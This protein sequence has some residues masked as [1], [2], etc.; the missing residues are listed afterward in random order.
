[1]NVAAPRQ[2]ATHQH[3]AIA[4]VA[5]EPAGIEP[6]AVEPAAVEPAAFQLA[7]LH[8]PAGA[9]VAVAMSGG[10]DSSVVAG[11][12]V[13]AGFEVIG[14][15]ARLSDAAP[16]ATTRAGSCCA[17]R[18]ARDARAVAAKLG[19]RHYVIDER[20]R[21]ADLVIAP[22]AA[23]WA[24]GLTP[25]PCVSCNR[26]LKFDLLLER[27]RLVGAVALCTGHYARLAPDAAGRWQL[28]RGA[29]PDKDQAYFLHPLRPEAAGSLRFPLG[30]MSKADVRAHAR[31]LGLA[32]AE[33]PESMDI[34]FTGGRPPGDWLSQRPEIK[35]RAGGGVL[36]AL[37]GTR[38]GSHA[39]QHRFTIGQRRG[40]GVAGGGGPLY[41]VAKESDGAVVLGD[42]A[43]LTVAEVDVADA[44]T[45]DGAPLVEGAFALAQWRHRGEQRLAQ[46][47][48]ATADRWTLR[49]VEPALAIAPGQSLVLTDAEGPD[50]GVRLLGGGVVA[51]TRRPGAPAEPASTADVALASPI[52]DAAPQA[53]AAVP[54]GGWGP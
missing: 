49:F 1:M 36:V 27:A 54:T 42:L 46:V 20:E 3:A 8:L 14:L 40:H 25:N 2:P 4:P 35:A 34:C 6:A 30:A 47:M 32:V 33:K 21:F 12:L 5:V 51:G 31:R 39:G 23:A 41:V 11:L 24:A 22:F 43:A 9:R 45:I 44:G 48:R 10:V 37:D 52:A 19:I 50:A 38:L 15:T 18:D 26:H 13:E 29:D 7:D 28:R 16:E 17:P 53:R